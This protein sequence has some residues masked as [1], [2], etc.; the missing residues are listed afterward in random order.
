MARRKQARNSS[1]RE[2]ER[3]REGGCVSLSL[4]PIFSHVATPVALLGAVLNMLWRDE[5]GLKGP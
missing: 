1:E 5:C 4:L 2:R 3:V